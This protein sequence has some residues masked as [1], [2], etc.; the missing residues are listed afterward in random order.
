MEIDIPGWISALGAII[1]L[2][3]FVLAEIRRRAAQRDAEIRR[4]AAQRDNERRIQEASRDLL[5]EARQSYGWS[6]QGCTSSLSILNEQGDTSVIRALHG[7]RSRRE[8]ANIPGRFLLATPGGRIA[9]E[10]PRFIGPAV[11]PKAV[12]WS[13]EIQNRNGAQE[14]EYTVTITNS[15]T[16]RDPP[17]N[18][19]IE[20]DY[21]RGVL[22]NLQAVRDAY[23]QDA[24]KW[25]YHSVRVAFPVDQLTLEVEFAEDFGFETFASVFYG[26]ETYHD[27]EFQR[28]HVG[29]RR[30]SPT[31]ST[32][33]I[34][35]PIL[36][37][38]YLI[39]WILNA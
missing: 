10:G 26:H 35:Q 21:E 33:K 17:L 24:F 23:A 7:I 5:Q 13:H 38:E 27:L 36:G 1:A 31:K 9:E 16:S 19:Q 14:I 32:F 22:M 30:N 18:Y 34:E 12:T 25:D 29:F 37:F 6:A 15:L 39:Y 3:A 28:V 4:R 8:V 2:V 11:F 20:V